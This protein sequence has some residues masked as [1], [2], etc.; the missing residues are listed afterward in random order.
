MRLSSTSLRISIVFAVA[1][2]PATVAP[3][4]DAHVPD[5]DAGPQ[6]EEFADIGA[7]TEGLAI[8][9]TPGGAPVLYVGTLDDRIVRIAPDGVVADFV[10]VND[11]LGIAVRED[12]S[13]V[14]AAKRA[15]ADGGAAVL[16]LIAP[17]GTTSELVSAGP[18]DAPLGVTNFVAIAPDGS[19]VFS[20]SMANRLFRADADG[21]EVTLITDA[22][23]Y[24][25]GLAFSPDGATLYV[26]SWDG[27]SVHALSFDR[28]TSS[29]G[30]PA[31]AQAGVANVDG[32]VSTID[33]ALYLV[34][35]ARGILRTDPASPAAPATVVPMGTIALPANAVFGDAAF[36]ESTLYVTSLASR[37]IHR[38]VTADR[39]APLPP[40]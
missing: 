11:P 2:A 39:G 32:I 12:G 24:P 4:A 15:E 14:V 17:D 36:G 38:I 25:N 29:Y 37:V 5:V 19:L 33:G 20:D 16:L 18:G 34:T 31:V 10:T 30:A 35:S 40:R 3:G 28:A 22:I 6:L 1:C 21:A 27:R 23:T 9:R 7:T 13:L 26:A 8:G